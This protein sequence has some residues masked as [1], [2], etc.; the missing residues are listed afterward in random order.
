MRES[1][2]RL[3]RF[4]RC[5]RCLVTQDSGSQTYQNFEVLAFTNMFCVCSFSFRLLCCIQIWCS[6][7]LQ[8]HVGRMIYLSGTASPN[9][10]NYVLKIN[11]SAH[12]TKTCRIKLDYKRSTAHHC[13]IRTCSVQGELLH[14]LYCCTMSQ[15]SPI[16]PVTFDKRGDHPIMLEEV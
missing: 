7:A 6:V 10:I 11:V 5:C 8:G 16:H 14:P 12:T 3:L 13:T 9:T 2:G 1:I 4:I 15:S